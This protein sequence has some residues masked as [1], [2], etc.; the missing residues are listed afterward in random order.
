MPKITN[1]EARRV[2]VNVNLTVGLLEQIDRASESYGLSRSAFIRQAVERVLEDADDI[3][4]SEGRLQDASDPVI[5]W[6]QV[7]A[8]AG[9]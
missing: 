6:R 9:L 3:A 7:K 5:P 1:A 2:A 8:E 4:V